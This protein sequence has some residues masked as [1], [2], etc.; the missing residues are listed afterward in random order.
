MDRRTGLILTAAAVAVAIFTC[1]P[2][3]WAE[4]S[5]DTSLAARELRPGA[6]ALQFQGRGYSILGD[7]TG[8]GLSF[9]RHWSPRSALRFGLDIT[10]SSQRIDDTNSEAYSD[11]T[12]SGSS[13]YAYDMRSSSVG[14]AFQY[15]CYPRARR[16][17]SPFFGIGPFVSIWSDRDV[18]ANSHTSQGSTVESGQIDARH[19]V[20][21]G[22]TGNVGMEWFVARG[23]SLVAQYDLTIQ[24]RPSAR[25]QQRAQGSQYGDAS[26]QHDTQ[27]S[28]VWDLG[29]KSVG[30]ALSLYF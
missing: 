27:T 29:M 6:W 14:V 24:Y 11:T 9:K 19:G 18:S 2:G 16:N 26:L 10:H 21:V 1:A 3:A 15:L 17:P 5:P 22:V 7:F 4:D 28:R 23:V 20:S 25:D 12:R 13:S 8:T 30:L